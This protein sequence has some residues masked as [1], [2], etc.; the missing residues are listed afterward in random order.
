MDI[1]I[2]F[3]KAL[4][5][6][7]TISMSI[8]M[9]FLVNCKEPEYE[10]ENADSYSKIFMQLASNGS[11]VKALPISDTWV[12]M[13]F[14]AGYGG[15]SPLGQDVEIS[16]QIDQ[17]QVDAYNLRNNT[18]YQ[19]PPAD[20]YRISSPKVTVKAGMAGSSSTTLEINS[21]KLS[22]TRSYLIPVSISNVMP[23]IPISEELRTTYFIVNGVYESNPYTPISKTGW[24]IVDVS[25]DQ[26]DGIGG[27]A[28]F[29]IDGD[30]NTCW[31]SRYSRV[32]NVRPVH[33]HHVTIDMKD[34][35]TL[36]GLQIFG[37]RTVPPQSSQA[38]LFPKNVR[39][40]LSDDGVTWETTGMY[41]ITAAVANEPEATIYFEQ[42]IRGRYMKVTVLNST[43]ANGD[44]TGI[45]ELI[46][47]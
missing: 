37:R 21:L 13:P 11:V 38:Y 36:H 40:E 17:N 8:L 4:K 28:R 6:L 23:Q 14:G 46:A 18:N 47:F 7:A 45:A 1:N 15:I 5:T 27:L 16:F 29:C 43:S 12:S 39:V 41:T 31:L 33:P 35:N 34:T 20:S 25:S 30:V 3:Y 19:L 22:G 32:N 42:S 24:E 9:L 2:R 10:I 26:A 44:T